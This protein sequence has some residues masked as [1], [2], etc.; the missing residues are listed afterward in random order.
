MKKKILL[1]LLTGCICLGLMLTYNFIENKSILPI[2]NNNYSTPSTEN[3]NPYA[4]ES[5]KS[6]D[7][8]DEGS[9]N[10]A[11]LSNIDILIKDDTFI[12]QL[13]DII[14]NIDTYSGKRIKIEGIISTIENHNFLVIRLYDMPHEEHAHEITVGI[15]A[16]FNGTLPK[17]DSWVTVIGTIEKDTIDSRIL[18][19]IKVESITES[20][21]YG[22][23]KVYN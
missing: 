14:T 4:T 2:N 5:I 19:R 22:Q 23:E 7:S 12:T 11:N 18:P 17:E 13:D 9:N 20:S 16:T 1:I 10:A 6:N 8:K 15:N 3:D 21:T